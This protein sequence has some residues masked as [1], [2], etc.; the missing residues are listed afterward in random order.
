MKI[1]FFS[2]YLSPHQ[3]PFC[4][5]MY[6]LLG[7]NFVFVSCEPYSEQ[8]RQMGWQSFEQKPYELRPYASRQ[9]D[10]KACEIACHWDVMIWGSANFKYVKLRVAS[11]KIHFRYSER[12]LKQGFWRSLFNLNFLRHIY[13]NVRTC[14]KQAFLLVASAYAAADFSFTLG[15]FKGK[16]KWG[17]FPATQQYNLAKLLAQKSANK[18]VSI[19]WAGRLIDLKHPQA[20]IFLAKKLREAGYHFVLNIIGSGPLKK[21]LEEK[22]KKL[23]LTDCVHLLGSMPS[24]QVRAHME[25]TDIFCFTSDF[26]EGWGAVLNESMNSACAVVASHAVGAVPFLIQHRQNGMVYKNGDLA[27]FYKQVIYL[28]EH[29]QVRKNMGQAAYHTILNSW[30]APMAAQRLIELI[31]AVQRAEPVPFKEGPC[32]PAKMIFQKDMYEYITNL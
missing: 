20:P 19:L 5:A 10:E 16:Y 14:S 25:C 4:E 2:N 9:E 1:A 7:K 30:N 24:D 12:L 18:K 15:C 3:L 31:K 17:Y 27:D 8:R 22:I 21:Q 6:G 11:G 28:I 29:P 26:N 32:S 13:Y 23:N